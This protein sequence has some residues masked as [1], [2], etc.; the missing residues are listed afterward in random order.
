ML[1]SELLHKIFNIFFF[2]KYIDKIKFIYIL[3]QIAFFYDN[4][5]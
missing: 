5:Y 4:K 2:K 1:D 3:T